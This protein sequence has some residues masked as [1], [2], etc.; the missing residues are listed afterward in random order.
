MVHRKKL[1]RFWIS[2]LIIFVGLALSVEPLSRYLFSR[3]FLAS[4][5]DTP[6]LERIV[7]SGAEASDLVIDGEGKWF[8]GGKPTE[9]VIQSRKRGDTWE[10]P[11]GTV[12][13]NL[14]L[15]GTIRIMGMGRN[16][17]S[18]A[19]RDSSRRE[20][21]TQ[22]AQEA[23]PSEV[24]IQNVHF[25][26]VQRIPLYLAPGVTRVTVENCEF[27]GKSKSVA[28]YL[29]AESGHHTIRGNRFATVTAREV[30][31][32]DGSANNE[33]SGNQFDDFSLGGIYLYR[34]CGEGGTVR[35][36]APQGN[37]IVDNQFVSS[38][39]GWGAYGIH[40][41]SRSGRRTYCSADD[42][43]PFGSSIDN[44]DFADH[45]TVSGNVFTS[46][47]NRMVRNEGQN[48]LI[49]LVQ[50][51]QDVR[52]KAPGLVSRSSGAGKESPHNPTHPGNP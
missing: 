45:N 24:L 40:I 23:A 9:L 19:V 39:L 49:S 25:E 50:G 32:V 16:G 12:I 13:R 7:Y 2:A 3:S 42:G 52:G 5:A 21:H 6:K 10:A 44:R 41:G 26:A 33:I 36:Q 30:I 28:V 34:N 27:A 47:T 18:L 15:R 37:R 11:T 20:T 43:Y 35:H 17:E 4:L 38:A 46:A 1:R 8:N 29:D 22:R 48:N 31:A 14:R 51:G